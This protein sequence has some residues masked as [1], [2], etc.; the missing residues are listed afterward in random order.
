MNDGTV[1]CSVFNL[2]IG[3]SV[4]IA[5]VTSCADTRVCSIRNGQKHSFTIVSMHE[6]NTRLTGVYR[7]TRQL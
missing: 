5:S 3:L 6:K 7:V 1:Y 2:F 4:G